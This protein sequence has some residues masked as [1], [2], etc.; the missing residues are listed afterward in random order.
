MC[1]FYVFFVF[2][3][4]LKQLLNICISVKFEKCVQVECFVRAEKCVKEKKICIKFDKSLIV[5]KT[6]KQNQQ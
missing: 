2:L 6:L 1:C 5:V 4:V 3:F